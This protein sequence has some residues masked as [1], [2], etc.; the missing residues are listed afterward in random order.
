MRCSV[1]ASGALLFGAISLPA[2]SHAQSPRN[3]SHADRMRLAEAIRMADRVA[4]EV[5]PG[6]GRTPLSVLLVT[7]SAEFLV[8]HPRP[9]EDFTR[10]GFD[11]LLSC[12]VLTRPRQ[13][14]PDLLATFPAVGGL[15]TI[16][17]GTAERS[18]KSSAA[19][20]M[21]LLHEHFHQWQY[22]LPGYYA[23]T[24]ALDLARGDS[25]GMWMLEYPFPYDSAPVQRA[26]RRLASALSAALD[27]PT[28][29]RATAVK[30]VIGARDALRARLSA[31]DY[32]YLE[33]QLWQEGAARYVEHA[34]ARNDSAATV[35]RRGLQEELM[36]LDLGTQ[37]R[38]AFYPLGDAVAR[39][40]DETR[41]GWKRDYAERPFALAA[42]LS[43]ER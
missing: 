8:G 33:F 41:P 7:D 21:T 23:G 17:M 16:V 29:R 37:R 43:S 42:L 6:W 2:A 24:A 22:S 40:L 14:S 12:E 19:W 31:P 39:L 20:V 35:D 28:E 27:A 36:R 11:T 5:W 34:V 38:I 25:T 4:E 3:L 13:F 9:T 10:L 30:T 18:G 32:R 26:V 15:P 1:L